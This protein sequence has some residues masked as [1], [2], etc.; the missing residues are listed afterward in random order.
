MASW[1][2]SVHQNQTLKYFYNIF[3]GVENRTGNQNMLAH[4]K[5]ASL[6][7]ITTLKLKLEKNIQTKAMKKYKLVMVKPK[8]KTVPFA[9]FQY[10]PG[11]ENWCTII[12]MGEL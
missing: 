7:T 8:A 4:K 6:L 2:S 1:V 5:T 11:F 9:I 10:R 3:M 12:L